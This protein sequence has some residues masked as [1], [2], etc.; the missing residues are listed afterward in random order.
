MLHLE[1]NN[2]YEGM[3]VI[4]YFDCQDIILLFMRAC[5]NAKLNKF[6]DCLVESLA[7]D[8]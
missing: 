1:V 5:G 6:F 2:Q 7:V 4:L 8:D 3:Y